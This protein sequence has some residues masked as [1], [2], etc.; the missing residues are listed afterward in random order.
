MQLRDGVVIFQR[1]DANRQVGCGPHAVELK[2]LTPAQTYIL[3]LLNARITP[4][5]IET[6]VKEH[7]STEEWEELKDVLTKMD[8]VT[9][10]QTGA[11]SD[12]GRRLM[13]RDGNEDALQWRNRA[14]LLI[15]AFP[16]ADRYQWLKL[17]PFLSQLVT[18]LF[19]YGFT[20]V[21]LRYSGT[22]VPS[23]NRDG[24]DAAVDPRLKEVRS[25]THVVAIFSHYW[26]ATE[27]AHFYRAGLDHL[28]VVV[29]DAQ[30]QVGPFVRVASGPCAYCLD[31]HAGDYD[32]SAAHVALQAR[33][34]LFPTL[35]SDLATLAAMHAARAIADEVDRRGWR[36][37]EIRYL[38]ADL[39]VER[40]RWPEHPECPH[41]LSPVSVLEEEIDRPDN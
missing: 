32:P 25:P 15:S 39:L 2:G 29:G 7:L 35:T 3:D 38:D 27:L 40:F 19:N 21:G 1:L 31:M 8:A 33:R 9:E 13:R 18:H 41:L 24:L 12:E 22:D 6:K 5:G 4:A 11:S 16:C 37:G 23:A 14:R 17:Q 10:T 34:Q 36:T 26:D 20:H 30:V 28:V